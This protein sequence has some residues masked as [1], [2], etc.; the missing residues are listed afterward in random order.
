MKQRTFEF[1]ED[2]KSKLAQLD[3]EGR[4]RTEIKC[5]KAGKSFQASYTTWLV[6]S[7]KMT[8]DVEIIKP[9][10]EELEI[11]IINFLS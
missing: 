8:V 10:L 11:F 4:E 3:I 1:T 9:T 2:F 6:S 7:P 5:K